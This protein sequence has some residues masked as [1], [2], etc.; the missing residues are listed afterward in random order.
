MSA[1]AVQKRSPFGLSSLIRRLFERDREVSFA[2]LR[3][4]ATPAGSSPTGALLL[5]PAAAAAFVTEVAAGPKMASVVAYA[6]DVLGNGYDCYD[7]RLPPVDAGF[8]WAGRGLSGHRLYA[9][10]AHRFGFLPLCTIALAAKPALAGPLEAAFAGW[11]RHDPEAGRSAYFSNLVVIQRLIACLAARAILSGLPRGPRL[12]GRDLD[13]RLAEIVQVD[14]QFLRPRLGAS[15]GN[16]HL[17][18]DR[19]AGWLLAAGA[20]GADDARTRQAAAA[21]EAELLAQTL[22]DGCSF[23]HSTHYHELVTEFAV[24]FL[25]VQDRCGVAVGRAA[26]ARIAAML[27]FQAALAEL[28][29]EFVDLGDCAED[30]ILPL[31]MTGYETKLALAA[32]GGGRGDIAGDGVKSSFLAHLGVTFGPVPGVDASDDGAPFEVGGYLFAPRPEGLTLFRTGPATGTQLTPGHMHSTF[33]SLYRRVG[34]RLLLASPGTYS[35][36]GGADGWRAYFAGR[37]CRSALSIDGWDPLAPLARNFRREDTGLRVLTE[38]ADHAAVRASQGT[39]LGADGTPLVTRGLLHLG[40]GVELVY[41]LVH[42][43]ALDGRRHQIWQFGPDVVV[44]RSGER[45]SARI[46]DQTFDLMAVPTPA[47]VAIHRGE[48]DPQRGWVSPAYGQKLPASQAVFSF[49]P[50]QVFVATLIAPSA[51]SGDWGACDYDLTAAVL[52]LSLRGGGAEHSVRLQC[53]HGKFAM[54]YTHRKI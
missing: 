26:R 16:N 19:F 45:V 33:L 8:D 6:S 22:A 1:P 50:R 13:R 49:A 38:H 25:G 18:A 32:L 42:A 2:S 5:P 41:D 46:G 34:D 12:T 36:D 7:R 43:P 28:G 51:W 20:H 24:L 40:G 9:L 54:T 21:F 35:Y 17:L 52:N 47:T 10:R 4:A 14:S 48:T 37:R 39:I 53:P 3:R 11:Q 27:R 29:P 44:A 15:F 30:P 23:E 31:N